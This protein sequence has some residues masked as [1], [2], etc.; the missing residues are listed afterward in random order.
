MMVKATL[1]GLTKFEGKLNKIKKAA[2]DA[3]F[4]ALASTAF[5]IQRDAVQSIQRGPKSG[6]TYVHGRKTHTASA[7]G[8]A[9]ASDTGNLAKGIRVKIDKD[10][11]VAQVISH[12]PYSAHLEFGTSRMAARPFMGPAFHRNRNLAPQLI[13]VD[14][15]QSIRK[16]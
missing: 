5:A 12:A 16:G 11:A 14:F 3:Q 6:E 4:K 7:P 2:Q 13:K 15:K 9:P 10:K 8:E 1:K